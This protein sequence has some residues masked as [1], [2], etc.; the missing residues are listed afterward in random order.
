V[1]NLTGRTLRERA[2]A[3]IEIAHPDDRKMLIEEA[4]KG[5]NSLPGSDLSGKRSSIPSW[6]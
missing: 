2:Q 3:L 6:V 1:A 5:Q 4:K